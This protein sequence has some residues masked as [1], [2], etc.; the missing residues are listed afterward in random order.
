MRFV[1]RRKH[2]SAFATCLR[3]LQLAVLT[4]HCASAQLV[5]TISLNTST[6]GSTVGAEKGILTTLSQFDLVEGPPGTGGQKAY[7]FSIPANGDQTDVEVSTCL[8]SDFDTYVVLLSDDPTAGGNPAVIAESSNDLKCEVGRAKAFLSTRLASGTY[9]IIV[10]GNAAEEGNFNLTVTGAKA[11]PT[12]VPWGLDRIDQRRLPLDSEYSVQ[13]DGHGVWIYVIDSGLRTSHIEF[14]GRAK[15]GYDFVNNKQ[16]SS[17]DCTGH[18]THVAGIMAGK[19]FGVSRGANV[20]GIRAFGCDNKAKTSAIVDAISWALV[21]SKVKARKSVIL[22]LMFRTNSEESSILGGAIR[23]IIRS[24]IPVIVPAGDSAENTCKFYPGSLDDVLAISSVDRT[25]ARSRSSNS[26]SCTN[27]FA[28]GTSVPSSWHTSDTAWRSLSGTTQAAAHVVGAVANLM[29][30]NDGIKANTIKNVIESISTKD[31]VENVPQNDST[32]L[33]FVRSVPRF[34]GTPPRRRRVF[35]FSV[36]EVG[37]AV[38]EATSGKFE[39]LGKTFRELL[40]VSSQELD[41]SCAVNMSQAT[42]GRD[43][44]IQLQ[45][46]IPERMAAAKFALLETAIVDGKEKTEESLGFAFNV[47]ELPWAVDSTPTVFWGAPTFPDTDS[48]KLSA[49]AIAGIA[50]AVVCVVAVIGAVGWVTYRRVTKADEIESMEGS[51]DFERGPVHFDDFKDTGGGNE[52]GGPRSFRNIVRALSMRRSGSMRGG[53][54]GG[55]AGRGLNSMGSFIGGPGSPAKEVV[56]VQSFGGEAFAGLDSLSRSS[57]AGSDGGGMA[58]R[59]VSGSGTLSF[60]GAHNLVLH[61]RGRGADA[62]SSGGEDESMRMRSVGGEAFAEMGLG[63]D[64]GTAGA[65]DGG[66]WTRRAGGG[67][68]DSI[69]GDASLSLS[70]GERGDSFFGG[71]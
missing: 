20:V 24:G 42:T 58:S 32:R 55:G 59:S 36:L 45:A 54:G 30:L 66:W 26:G 34:T 10:T 37:D 16:E 68:E 40:S 27:L 60:R 4:V 5:I 52:A 70:G 49:G 56:R 17:F 41:V 61:G 25:D 71:T 33:V 7:Q 12:P 47:F 57:S 28:P 35:L 22:S 38:C 3:V 2:V 31:V 62:D 21:D 63:A 50:T 15:A 46:E 14:E 64:R 48:A 43:A 44:L 1:Q 19:N 69:R 6:V 39:A 8:G 11:T 65:R 53:V 29:A 67:R 23:G 13:D 51:A 9:F 18:G